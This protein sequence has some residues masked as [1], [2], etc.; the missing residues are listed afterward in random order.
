MDLSQD[1]D[2][3]ALTEQETSIRIQANPMITLVS[4]SATMMYPIALL[5]FAAIDIQKEPRELLPKGK[6]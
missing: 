4:S 6:G 5:G 1:N 3:S 2:L